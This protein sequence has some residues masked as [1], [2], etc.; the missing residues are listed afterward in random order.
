MFSFLTELQINLSIGCAAFI[1]G[2]VL[3]TKVKDYIKGIPA[4]ARVALNNVEAKAL[5]DVRQAQATALAQ[6][7]GAVPVKTPLPP[8]ALPLAPVAPAP[9]PV[10][11]SPVVE[12]AK[13]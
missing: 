13:V 5:A 6:I 7:P 3:S 8:S 9:A 4:Q 12:P 11:A 1:A 2:V 10:A